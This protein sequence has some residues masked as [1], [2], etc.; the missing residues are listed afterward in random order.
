MLDEQALP[1]AQAIERVACLQANF[2][3]EYRTDACP[4][5]HDL[6]MSVPN[7]FMFLPS[8]TLV[9]GVFRSGQRSS[10]VTSWHCCMRHK[11]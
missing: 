10:D 7:E 4:H 9:I 2:E 5:K 1:A 8:D 6:G 3:L 11:Q